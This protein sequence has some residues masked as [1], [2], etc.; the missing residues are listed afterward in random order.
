M[1][2][3][4]NSV[5]I[6]VDI[7][8]K[9]AQLMHEKA[10]LFSNI[11]ILV[12]SAKALDLPVIWVEQIPEKMGPTIEQISTHLSDMTPVSK[13]SFSC[14]GDT[15]FKSRLAALERKQLIVVGIEAHVCVFQTVAD[16]VEA[17]YD[18]QVVADAIS[19][20]TDANKQI[21]INRMRSL[22]AEITS[23]EMLLFEL[24]ENS[25]HPHFREISR[26]IR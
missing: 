7:Q 22:G 20:R 11:E 24:L 3:T 14:Y 12:K 6:L 9:L 1:F 26:H 17:G 13:T 8:G 16:M 10:S 4:Q 15:V 2:D 5:L 18:V 21:A 25:D 19:S 23:T